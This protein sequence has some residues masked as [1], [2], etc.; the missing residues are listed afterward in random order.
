MAPLIIAH[1][2]DSAHFPEN[3]LAAFRS[4]LKLQSDLVEFDVQLTRDAQVVVIHDASVDRTTDGRGRLRD[5]TLAEVQALSAGYPVRFGSAFAGERVPT[6]GEALG[7]LKGRGRAMIEIKSESVNA[8]DDGGIEAG[9]VAEVRRA[10]M[11]ADAVLISFNRKALLRCRELAPEIQRGHLFH[12]GTPD[13]VVEA[14]RAVD[15]DLVMPEKGMLSEALAHACHAAGLKIATWVVD[16][17][18]ELRGL[19]RYDLFGVGSNRPGVLLDAIW[20]SE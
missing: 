20:E 3:T 16:D 13:D 17:V 1:R 10:G 8:H 15:T 4:A 19:A 6:L 2:G 14:A 9:T 5:M 12:R 18:D 7:V 11:A